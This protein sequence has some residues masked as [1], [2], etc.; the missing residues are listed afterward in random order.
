MLHCAFLLS[1]ECVCLNPQPQFTEIVDM[2]VN[3]IDERIGGTLISMPQLCYSSLP[4][5][6][7]GGRCKGTAEHFIEELWLARNLL[8]RQTYGDANVH[9][10][11]SGMDRS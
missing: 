7:P 9:L 5:V 2:I 8:H 6:D 3:A 1:T 4:V 10:G 11:R